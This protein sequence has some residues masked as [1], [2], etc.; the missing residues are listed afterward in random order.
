MQRSSLISV[1]VFA[2]QV[3]VSRSPCRVTDIKADH[4]RRRRATLG[5]RPWSAFAHPS[6]RTRWRSGIHVTIRLRLSS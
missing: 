5:M 6:E 4:C 2:F 1:N 3:Y